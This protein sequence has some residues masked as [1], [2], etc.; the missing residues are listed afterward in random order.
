LRV[1]MFIGDSLSV[2]GRRE[3]TGTLTGTLKCWCARVMRV[4]C[5]VLSRGA[6]GSHTNGARR[7]P[8]SPAQ[9]GCRPTRP[10]FFWRAQVAALGGVG[11]TGVA[12]L[13]LLWAHSRRT[14]AAA[15]AGRSP[16]WGG[17]PAPQKVCWFATLKRSNGVNS[18]TVSPRPRRRQRQAS[19]RNR[20][21]Q[22][23]AEHQRRRSRPP[24]QRL[25]PTRA[26]HQR[27]HV[28]VA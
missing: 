6:S 27:L 5:C 23:A 4:D 22:W 8:C 19:R 3:R 18:A 25:P 26:R 16:G 14:A 21:R 17:Q 9:L 20:R 10:P 11:R 2:C 12:L 13:R 28:H 24:S 15:A 1:L 7:S